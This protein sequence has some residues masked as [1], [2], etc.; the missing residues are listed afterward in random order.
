MVD[1]AE[2]VVGELVLGVE[3][4]HLEVQVHGSLEVAARVCLEAALQD[5]L[6]LFLFPAAIVPGTAGGAERQQ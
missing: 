1:H 2:V 6:R 5:L 3:L 4:D